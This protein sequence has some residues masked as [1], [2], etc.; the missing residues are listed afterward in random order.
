MKSVVTT[1]PDSVISVFDNWDRV[2]G[3]FFGRGLMSGTSTASC[4]YP[5][6]DIREEKDR[7]VLEAELPGLSEK[8]VDIKIK[9]NILTLASIKEES[10]EKKEGSWIIRERGVQSFRRAFSL[11]RDVN[12]EGIDAVFKDGLLLVNIPKRPEAQEKS[13]N[14]KRA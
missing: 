9:D 10:E 13:I 2:L 14:I 11:P 5:A 12:S 6:V 8:D 3:N 4:G 7:Y 1:N